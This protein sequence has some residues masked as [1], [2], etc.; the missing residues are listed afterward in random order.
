MTTIDKLAEKRKAGQDIF[1]G[2]TIDGVIAYTTDPTA[3]HNALREKCLALV[4]YRRNAGALNFQLEK[5][6][7]YI[8]A[9][10]SEL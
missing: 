4:Q 2:S 1:R 5:L 8:R 3:R 7:D 10:V 9:I 6:D